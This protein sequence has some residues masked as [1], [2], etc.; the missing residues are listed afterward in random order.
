M[1]STEASIRMKELRSEAVRREGEARILERVDGMDPA[2]RVRRDEADRLRDQARDLRST[3][4]LENLEVYQVV[5][6]KVT[7]KGQTRRYTYYHASW[8]E[9]EKVASVYLGSAK[10]MTEAVAL[11][12]ARTMKAEAL[13]L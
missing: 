3:W 13:G 11:Q 12:K 1:R 9:G 4:R 6:E 5:K 8:R 10:R 2:A 7:T